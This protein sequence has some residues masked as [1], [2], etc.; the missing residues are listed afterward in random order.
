MLETFEFEVPP[1]L[2]RRITALIS[3]QGCR[4]RP[5]PPREHQDKVST[6]WWRQVRWLEPQLRRAALMQPAGCLPFG[7]F[8]AL[9]LQYSP[10]F[11]PQSPPQRLPQYPPPGPTYLT[12]YPDLY[13]SMES[14]CLLRHLPQ[15]PAQYLPR[16]PSQYLTEHLHQ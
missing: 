10:Q 3:L 13:P 16:H 6:T 1:A 2:W 15:Y 8:L 9:S 12:I 5:V 11:P 14:Q 7:I 4:T